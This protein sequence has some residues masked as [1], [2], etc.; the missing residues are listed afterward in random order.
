MNW[1]LLLQACVQGVVEGLTE[2]LPVSST[3]HL[4]VSG[5]LIGFKGDK[6]NVFEI[7]IQ[8]GAILAVCYEYR[9]RLY[10]VSTGLL[11]NPTSQRFA[12]NVIIAFLPA[13]FLGL[14]FSSAIKTH[15]FNPVSVAVAFIV[16]GFIMLWAE[17]RQHN[18][19]IETLDAIKPMDAFK[20]GLAQCAALIPGTSRS[21]AT[22]IGG[23]LFGFSRTTATEFSF[24][25]AIPTIFA[26]TLYDG[27]KHRDLL[28]MDDLPMFA[29]GFLAAFISAQF[30]IRAFL[31]FIATH[32]FVIFAWYRIAFGLLILI[33]AYVGLIS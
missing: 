13:A 11:N 2:F 12:T 16:G 24:F 25:L 18:V 3:G 14:L 1:I 32:S 22:I 29:V 9:V 21:G 17:K 7:V 31:K 15:L 33:L 4:I 8:S 10:E 23:L 27:W 30:A 6:A 28:S 5:A 20:I 19:T 26:A